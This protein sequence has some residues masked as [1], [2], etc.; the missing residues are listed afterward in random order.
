VK[1]FL[2]T[3]SNSLNVNTVKMTVTELA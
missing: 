3:S 2:F 1:H